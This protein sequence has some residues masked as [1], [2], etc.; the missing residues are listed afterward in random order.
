M[1]LS[2]SAFKPLLW[3]VASPSTLKEALCRAKYYDT[4]TSK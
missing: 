4:L 3:D 2:L 1:A